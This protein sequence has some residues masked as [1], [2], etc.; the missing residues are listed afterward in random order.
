MKQLPLLIVCLLS[1]SI[2]AISQTAESFDISTFQAP[3]GWN[4]QTS[5]SSIQFSTE[6]K[7]NG[8]YCLITL[9]TSLPGLGA[10][11]ENF[12]A[13]W[14]T[15][16]KETVNVSAPPQMFPS[17]NK[18]DWKVEG[19]FSSFEITVRRVLRCFIP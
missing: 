12:S 14:E 15:I 13:A 4:K 9:F 17:D 10:P 18:E 16:V 2:A 19:G 6:D 3:K 8:T 7:A 5:Q 1:L 11:K